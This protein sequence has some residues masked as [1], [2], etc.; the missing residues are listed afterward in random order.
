[1]KNRNINHKDDW[2]TPKELYDLLDKEFDFDFDPCPLNPNFDGLE[3]EWGNNIFINFGVVNTLW[4]K[5]DVQVVSNI[6]QSHVLL[7]EKIGKEDTYHNVKNAIR[8]KIQNE[9]E[10]KSEND[11]LNPKNINYYSADEHDV[12]NVKLSNHLIKLI[13]LMTKDAKL[14]IVPTVKNAK[15]R[16]PGS[17]WKKEDG[18]QLQEILSKIKNINIVN[19]LKGGRVNE[20][21]ALSEIT[22]VEEKFLNGHMM[23]GINVNHILKMNVPIAEQ[24]QNLLKIIISLYH[25]IHTQ[26]QYH[27]IWFQP[28]SN[29]IA[30]KDLICPLNGVHQN[31]SKLLI[32]ISNL[33]LKVEH[34]ANVFINPP[35]SRMLKEAFIR[36]AF[37]QSQKGRLSVM[38]LPV[39]TSTKIFHE[40]IYPNAEIRFLKGRVKFEGINTFGKL[41][42]NKCGMHDSMIVIFRGESI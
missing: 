9:V 28:V 3:I 10:I 7:H 14:D 4:K 19:L 41:V 21:A 35:Y 34:K 39:S 18:I 1:M 13:F 42:N 22:N 16:H 8:L 26:E 17:V 23:T 32:D 11:M 36:K 30:P 27:Q 33:S 15:E 31:L 5:S 37:E 6:N 2:A 20:K 40:V 24:R 12:L 29:A 38:L 25:V